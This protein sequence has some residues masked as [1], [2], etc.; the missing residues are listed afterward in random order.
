[1][2]YNQRR[3][4]FPLSSRLHAT[5][6]LAPIVSLTSFAKRAPR[7]VAAAGAPPPPSLILYGVAPD[8]AAEC[9]GIATELRLART[10]VK[11][12]QAA[13]AALKAH[14]RA[15]LIASAA[16]RSWDREVIEEHAIRA[17]IPLR[18]VTMDHTADEVAAY[19]RAWAM[20]TL[21]RARTLR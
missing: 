12:L 20:D 1:M 14:P 8:V 15:I 11:H 3:H 19:V 7:G 18:W 2:Q 13:C 9:E 17:G 16:I 21:R 5:E 6:S 10:E 4:P